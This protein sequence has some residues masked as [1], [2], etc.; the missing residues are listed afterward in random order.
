[1]SRWPPEILIIGMISLQDTSLS[2]DGS[3]FVVAREG[4]VNRGFRRHLDTDASKCAA[5]LADSDDCATFA[6]I[7]NTRLEASSGITCK[8]PNPE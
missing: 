3:H 4:I 5:M 1:M 2:P 8:G 6:N 7:H